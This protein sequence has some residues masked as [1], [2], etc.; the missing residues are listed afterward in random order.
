MED[1]NA[2]QYWSLEIGI[3]DL[4]DGLSRHLASVADGNRIVVTDHGKPIAQIVPLDQSSRM[5][6]LVKEGRVT[7]ASRPKGDPGEPIDLG[8]SV[9]DYLDR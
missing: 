6:Q 3:R 8:L 1:K 9:L 7:P 5:E 4:R 2:T